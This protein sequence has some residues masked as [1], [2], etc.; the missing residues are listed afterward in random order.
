MTPENQTTTPYALIGGESAV[1]Q[2][3]KRFYQLMDELPEAYEV[4]KLH[5]ENL[6]GSETMLFEYLSTELGECHFEAYLEKVRKQMSK[7]NDT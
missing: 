1:R 3:V 2:L 6:A 7:E 5:P 4:R